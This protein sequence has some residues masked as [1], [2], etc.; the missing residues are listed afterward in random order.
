[1]AE[2]VIDDEGRPQDGFDDGPPDQ[3]L[4]TP[5]PAMGMERRLSTAMTMTDTAR[6]ENAHSAAVIS[7]PDLGVLAVAA[8][9]VCVHFPAWWMHYL[10]SVSAAEPV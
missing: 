10:H 8:A 2:Q 4:S 5:G 3:P 6:W 9:G 1:M 7:S